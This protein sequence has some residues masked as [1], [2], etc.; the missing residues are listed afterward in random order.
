MVEDVRLAVN[1]R[2]PVT[3]KGRM[4]GVIITP[5][6]ILQEVEEQAEHYRLVRV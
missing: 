5:E 4:G 3:F 2:R 1:G 6:E